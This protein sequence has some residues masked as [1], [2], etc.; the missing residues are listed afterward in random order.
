MLQC[1]CSVEDH[2]WR[3]SVVRTKKWRSEPCGLDVTISAS[4][5]WSVAIFTTLLESQESY[6]TLRNLT[7][8]IIRDFF[9]LHGT[10]A[11]LYNAAASPASRH[12]STGSLAIIRQ[13]TN[14]P[15]FV[16]IMQ[17]KSLKHRSGRGCPGIWR[18]CNQTSKTIVNTLS[19]QPFATFKLGNNTFMVPYFTIVHF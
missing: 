13:S 5:D 14:S 8:Q 16:G 2:S 18:T 11:R 4:F 3:Q 19:A 9:R 17:W 15:E 7:L 10:F 6:L 12:C 1:V